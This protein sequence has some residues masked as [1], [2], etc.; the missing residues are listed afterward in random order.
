ML[1]QRTF[2][3]LSF[4]TVTDGQHSPIVRLETNQRVG[5]HIQPFARQHAAHVGDGQRFGLIA[6]RPRSKRIHINAERNDCD[7]FFKALNL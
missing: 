4:R 6:W 2:K 5:Q 3:R 7:R 1:G